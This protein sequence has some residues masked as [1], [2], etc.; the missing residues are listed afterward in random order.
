MAAM[1]RYYAE[2]IVEHND[3]ACSIYCGM[4]AENTAKLA[5][6]TAQSLTID[7]QEP[8]FAPHPIF[9]TFRESIRSHLALLNDGM[10]NGGVE[11]DGIEMVPSNLEV[12]G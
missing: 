12:S 7:P 9:E 6:N 2:N 1:T 4:T 5:V 3:L 8:V 10:E 11:N